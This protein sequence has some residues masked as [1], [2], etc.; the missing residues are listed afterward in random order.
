VERRKGKAEDELRLDA[1]QVMTRFLRPPQGEI[2]EDILNGEMNGTHG[3]VE[4]GRTAISK[5]FMSN[6]AS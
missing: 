4:D 6:S 5:G 2:D 1:A 3:G